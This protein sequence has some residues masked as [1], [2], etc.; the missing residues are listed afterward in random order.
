MP[1]GGAPRAIRRRLREAGARTDGDRCRTGWR[2]PGVT[3][4]GSPDR[5]INSAAS[6]L[7]WWVCGY[8]ELHEARGIH[9]KTARGLRD[10]CRDKK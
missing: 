4:S 2:L 5:L 8:A 9:G 6:S 10:I 7:L 3:E 1:T